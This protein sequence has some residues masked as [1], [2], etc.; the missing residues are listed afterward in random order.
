MEPWRT[1]GRVPRATNATTPSVPPLM[2][3]VD[4]TGTTAVQSGAINNYL[5]RQRA[6]MVRVFNEQHVLDLGAIAFASWNEMGHQIAI[7]DA[8]MGVS[9]SGFTQVGRRSPRNV[10]SF[11]DA[12]WGQWQCWVRAGYRSYRAAFQA[13]L[14]TQGFKADSHALKGFDVDHLFSAARAPND[15]HVIRLVLVER[16][17]NRSWGSWAEKL[18]APRLT[19]SRNNAR[20][21]HVAKA[22]GVPAPDRVP[23]RLAEPDGFAA[24]AEALKAAGVEE[25][26][27]H[28]IAGE[29]ATMFEAI[30]Q[31]AV[32]VADLRSDEAPL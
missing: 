11:Y 18:D 20:Y 30:H 32:I 15:D 24:L 2:G 12:R 13:W 28:P 25:I 5:D 14:A 21:L 16:R 7:R 9:G 19:K 10:R 3:S 6:E 4:D 1:F 27:G 23:Q 31:Q 17:V 22:V 26:E 29:I 8:H